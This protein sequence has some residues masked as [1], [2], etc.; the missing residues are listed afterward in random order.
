MK[1]EQIIKHENNAVSRDPLVYCMYM[2]MY[3]FLGSLTQFKTVKS[4]YSFIPH[5][6][7]I[8]MNELLCG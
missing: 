4:F 7:L 5:V 2:S 8:K 3:G 6:V 1:L